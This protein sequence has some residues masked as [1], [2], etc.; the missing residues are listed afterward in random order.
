MNPII[1]PLNYSYKKPNEDLWVLNTDDLPIDM[2][3]V[4]DQQ[5]IHFAPGSKGGNHKHPRTEWF[6]G[7]GELL[8]VWVDEDEKKHQDEMNPNGKIFLFEVP[9]FLPHVVINSSKNREAILF[10]L[11]DSKMSSAEVVQIVA[12]IQKV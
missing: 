2:E 7:F 11:A 12:D 6:V 10:E 4:K 1:T 8:F 3:K 5:L 9:P